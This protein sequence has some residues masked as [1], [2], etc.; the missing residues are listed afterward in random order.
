[1]LCFSFRLSMS[2]D[3]INEAKMPAWADEAEAGYDVDA[4]LSRGR[5]CPGRG[6]EPMQ[7]V[8]SD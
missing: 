2:E 7:S 5:G 8:P 4:S 6:A 1:M 3:S